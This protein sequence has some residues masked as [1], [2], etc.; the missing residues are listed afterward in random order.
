VI[1]VWIQA[2]LLFA[3]IFTFPLCDS[4][5][6]KGLTMSYELGKDIAEI[7]SML[8]EL[9]KDSGSPI[10]SGELNDDS[11]SKSR[12]RH[13]TLLN[14]NNHTLR[15]L[16]IKISVDGN[17][18]GPKQVNNGSSI[19]CKSD[20]VSFGGKAN[21]HVEI[22]RNDNGNQGGYIGTY[23]TSVRFNAAGYDDTDELTIFTLNEKTYLRAVSIRVV[24]VI[25]AEF[26]LA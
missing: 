7:K 24:G 9:L 23:E 4:K 25:I 3:M 13:R 12:L 10:E 5:M 18:A 16:W 14:V 1:L 26:L 22:W 8:K 6:K 15:D 17:T 20:D 21:Y 2:G 11:Y 19:S